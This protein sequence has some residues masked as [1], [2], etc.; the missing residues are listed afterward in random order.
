MPANNLSA[1]HTELSKGSLLE[2]RAAKGCLISLRR[3]NGPN[4]TEL[5]YTCKPQGTSSSAGEQ[6]KDIYIAIRDALLEEGGDLSS[7][8]S[9]TIFMRDMANDIESVRLSKQSVID[10]SGGRIFNPAVTEIQQPPLDTNAQVEVAVQAILPNTIEISK[11]QVCASTGCTCGQCETSSGLL[12][13]MGDENRLMA[14]GLCGKGNNAYEQTWSMFTLAETLL[15]EAGMEFT[16]VVRTWIYLREMERDYY[17]GL[18]KARREFFDS[19]GIDPV[20]ASTGIEGGMVSSKHD[21]C[22]GFYAVKSGKALMRTV[23]TT[24]TLNEAGEY[25]ADFT[26]GMQM[27]EANKVALHVSGTASI[28]EQGRT[29]HLNDIGAQID[30]MILNI[31]TLL[32]N[33]G[34]SFSDIA[35]AYNYLKDPADEQLLKDKFKEAGLE[36]FPSIFVHAEVCRPDLLCETE[37]LA[38]LPKPNTKPNHLRATQSLH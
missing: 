11:Q 19:R 37:V 3:I 20:P 31:S 29:A 17:P 13:E 36:G 33:Q 23:M 24:P 25:G 18:N 30:R 26:R 21:I 4:A 22:M 10:A 38:I 1:S 34:A 32:Q 15:H 27:T 8:I 6:A 7:I 12:L 9:E 16:D 35:Y 5:F 28:D 14:G 2:K